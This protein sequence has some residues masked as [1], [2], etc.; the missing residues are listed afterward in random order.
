[1]E[2]SLLARARLSLSRSLSLSLAP[3]PAVKPP[4]PTAG[5]RRRASSLVVRSPET[6][7]SPVQATPTAVTSLRLDAR[8]SPS[9]VR[10]KVEDDPK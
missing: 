7:P 4:P 2:L 1:M 3:L 8:P 9:A 6:R 5:A 10:R